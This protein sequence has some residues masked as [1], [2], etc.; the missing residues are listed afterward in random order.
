MKNKIIRERE[1]RA[2][3]GDL[4]AKFSLFQIYK[5]GEDVEVNEDL[6]KHYFN[7]CMDF[8]LAPENRFILKKVE[9]YDFRRFD[10]LEIPFDS[11]L[12]VLIGNNGQGKT[13]IMDAISKTLSWINASLIMQK[14][15]KEVQKVGFSDIKNDSQQEFTDVIA[16]FN[17]GTELNTWGSRLSKAKYGSSQKRDNQI[18]EL[19]MIANLLRSINAEKTINL[20]LF[21]FYSVE[22]TYPPEQLRGNESSKREDRFDAYEGALGGVGKFANFIGWYSRLNK[23]ISGF[24]T[25]EPSTL[26]NQLK[27]E[28]KGLELSVENGISSLI[29]LLQSKQQQLA[30]LTQNQH[31]AEDIQ[32]LQLINKTICETVPSISKIWFD[33]T[34]GQ[35]VI[36]LE[37][38]GIDVRLDQLSDGQRTYMALVADIARRMILLNPLLPNP[39]HGQGIVLIDEIELH[40][41]PIWQ[42]DIITSLQKAF[43]NIQ[44]I[45]TTHS[46]QVLS[47]VDK[48]CIRKFEMDENGKIR[49]ITPKFQTKGVMSA[50]ILARIMGTNA[51]PNIAEAKN[52]EHFSELLSLNKREEA[53]NLLEGTLIPHFGEDHPV[54]LDCLNLIKIFEMKLRLNNSKS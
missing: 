41:H 11:C 48:K 35:D 43:P 45:L 10:Y 14:G 32:T 19:R 42:Q 28:I 8:L 24:K 27:E 50:D 30:E 54:I 15:T 52:V 40:L 44:F 47:T 2:K 3:K 36:W 21:A 39:L 1:Q 49:I 9:L 53:K 6:A 5:N 34:S 37:N 16:A 25:D 33:S 12:T 31:V 29:P 18:Q 7:E 46:P 51:I 26:L 23:K 20:P 17:Y 4:L 38:D 22:R 13:T